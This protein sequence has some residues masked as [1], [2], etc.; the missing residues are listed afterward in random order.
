M[1][2]SERIDAEIAKFPDWRGETLARLRATICAADPE[3]QE[4]W[5]WNS[6]VFSKNGIVCSIA[7][8][9]SHVKIHFFKGSDLSDPHGLINAGE[10]AKQMRSIDFR[11]GDSVNEPA[12]Q[13]LVRE[14]IA[15]NVKK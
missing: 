4:E 12:L 14:A 6:P 15:L 11:E 1:T 3:L 2:V 8:F 10:T 7:G 5:K 9:K 13:D